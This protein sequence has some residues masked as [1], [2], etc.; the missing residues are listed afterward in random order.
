LIECFFALGSFS[1]DIAS[2]WLSGFSHWVVSLR[3]LQAV[4]WVFFILGGFS[5]N[6]ASCWLSVFSY[7]RKN[8]RSTACNILRI[9]IE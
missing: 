3:I 7:M 6:I 8:T 5:Q 1:Q 4:D 9:T 2:Y